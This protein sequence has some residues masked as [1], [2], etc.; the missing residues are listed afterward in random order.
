MSMKAISWA[1]DQKAGST[2]AKLVLVLLADAA[3][4]DGR[5]VL[6]EKLIDLLAE[7]SEIDHAR[8]GEYL[9]WLSGCGL[10]AWVE[11][12]QSAILPIDA[13]ASGLARALIGYQGA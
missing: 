1:W 6:R 9:A 5:V 10:I 11:P 13:E 8:L 3:G 4:D 7:R 2:E 12:F